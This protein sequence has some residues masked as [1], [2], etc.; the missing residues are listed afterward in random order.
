MPQHTPS[1][2]PTRT[3]YGVANPERVESELWQKAVQEN[4]NGYNVR[5]YL[6][7]KSSARCEDYSHSS[8]RESTP[9]P[10]WSWER[11]GRTSTKLPDGRI[12]HIAGEHEDSY[13]PDFCIYNDVVVE[14]PDGRKEFYLYPCDVFPPTDFHSATLIGNEIILIGSLGYRDLRR[15]GE[16]QVLKLDT[17]TLRIVPAATTGEG[18]GWI[19]RHT[20]ERHESSIIVVGGRVQTQDDYEANEGVF[21]L[22]LTTMTWRPRPHGDAAIFP[23][24]ADVYRRCKNPRYGTANPER[25]ENPF[26]LEMAR[27]GWP[28]SRARLHFGDFAPPEPK[29]EPLENSPDDLEFGTPEA[30]AWI[31]RVSAAMDRNKLVR[32]IDDVVWTAEREETLRM[33]L[34]D[35]RALQIGGEVMDYGDEYADPWIYNDVIVTHSN[36]AIDILTY[37][38]EVF[39]L[40]F[41]SAV[42]VL[43]DNDVYIFGMLTQNPERPNGTAVLRL[44]ISSYEIEE[45]LVPPPSVRS[46]VN[47]YRGADIRHGNHIVFPLVRYRDS[48]PELG[49]A[50]DLE[51]LTWSAPFLHAHPRA[52]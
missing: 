7:A 49:I 45:V 3:R 40:F 9:G 36:G 47:I 5:Q 12:L 26:W 21:E 24:S 28:P 4:W 29:W 20:A 48:D 35:G 6:K 37:P 16:T 1:D 34:P 46:R 42:G 38:K 10:F 13:D 18:P 33:A 51:T 14:H 43:Y 15:L 30:D 2:G 50:F 39:P 44:N 11:F 41:G 17:R 25:S 8:Y 19:S 31:M 32:T 52:D 23:V 22:D 27:R